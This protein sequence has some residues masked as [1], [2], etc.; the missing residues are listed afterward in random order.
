MAK[1]ALPIQPPLVCV[2]LV[3]RKYFL[4]ADCDLAAVPSA[5]Q[6][7]GRCSVCHFAH[8]RPTMPSVIS[9]PRSQALPGPPSAIRAIILRTTFDTTERWEGPGAPSFRAIR[10]MSVQWADQNSNYCA[11]L[12]W[13]CILIN[14]P[15]P[16]AVYV[17]H[18]SLVY[19]CGKPVVNMRYISKHFYLFM[20]LSLPPDDF[21][22]PDSW[23]DLAPNVMW[24]AHSFMH[25]TSN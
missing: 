5:V 11:A 24:A 23:L 12:G 18:C 14:A 22:V 9:T 8:A 17:M 25:N 4:T 21:F 20:Q 10:A 13:R 6:S 7:A 19:V 16:N 1:R 3:R 2:A 15:L